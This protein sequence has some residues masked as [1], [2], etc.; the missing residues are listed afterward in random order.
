MCYRELD[1]RVSPTEE[2]MK[3]IATGIHHLDKDLSQQKYLLEKVEMTDFSPKH[4]LFS[5]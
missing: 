4:S 2:E 5:Q 1:A 3:E